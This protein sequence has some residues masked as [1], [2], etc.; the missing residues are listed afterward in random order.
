MHQTQ[1]NSRLPLLLLISSFSAFYI[2]VELLLILNRDIF[3]TQGILNTIELVLLSFLNLVPSGIFAFAI[4]SA[5][6]RVM[7]STL[8]DETLIASQHLIVGKL[9]VASLYTTY[10]D[11]IPNYALYNLTEARRRGRGFFILDDSNDPRKRAEV[12]MFVQEYNCDLVR[13]DNRK[14]YKAGAINCW[15]RKYSGCYD[16]VFILDSDSQASAASIDYCVELARRDPKLAVIQSKTLTITSVPNK[17][18]LSAVTIQHAYMAVVQAAMKNLGT[19]PFYGH[20][21]LLKVEALKALGGLVEESNEDY[22][23]LARLQNIGFNSIY[24]SNAITYEEI[25]PDYFSSRKRALR[26]ARDAVGQL[27]LLRY[28]APGAMK[29]Y[30]VYGW[31]TYMANIVLLSFLVLLAY[32]GFL[33]LQSGGSAYFAEMAGVMTMAILILWPLL[34]LR[35]KDSELTIRKILTSIAWSSLFNAPMMGPVSVQIVKTSATQIFVRARR[36]ISGID[37]KLVEEFVVTPKVST[38]SQTFSSILAS[39]KAEFIIGSLP[40]TVGIISGAMYFLLFSSPQLFMLI[41]LPI[42]IF[43]QGARISRRRRQFFDAGL[44]MSV[45]STFPSYGP[46]ISQYGPF[47]ELATHRIR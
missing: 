23:T 30:L 37:S 42:V 41:A 34:S 19:S 46:A 3:G 6:P 43:H 47:I 44:G 22:K 40:L 38:K 5:L 10:N 27:G 28:K 20:N 16:Y 14:G 45:A 32:N 36:A 9:K 31:A 21:A 12:D 35:V 39:L 26:W 25:P 17:L 8:N 33:P 13:R 2:T 4:V 15:L 1:S 29:F 11:F 18:T 7:V 24:A